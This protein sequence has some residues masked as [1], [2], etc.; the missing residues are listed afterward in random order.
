MDIKERY[1]E[2]AQTLPGYEPR[3]AQEAMVKTIYDVIEAKKSLVIEAGTGS[4]K[5]FGYLIP[6]LL[7]TEKRPIVVSTGT[8][9]LQEQLIHK[10]LPF[11]AQ[12]MGLTELNVQ[13]VKGRRNY[14]CIQK[15]LEFERGLA[16]TAKER[17]YVSAIKAGLES[18][19]DGD[20][21]TFDFEILPEIWEEI[22]SDS[23]DCLGSRCQF[24][25]ENPYK[26]ARENLEK[27]DILVTNHALYLQD[28]VAGQ[29]VLPAHEVVVFDEA[30]QIKNYA[31]RGFTAR[32]GRFA[33]QKLL[34]KIDKRIT[35][36]PEAFYEP[37][38]ENES[39]LMEWLFR[40]EKQTFSL[41]PDEAFHELV[42][43][44]SLLLTELR[45]WLGSFDM[46][47]MTLNTN[48]AEANKLATQR[49]KLIK[50]L[51]GLCG[52]WELFLEASGPSRVHWA[53]IL[54]NRLYYELRST[55]LNI[56]DLLENGLWK[57]KT[58][59]LTSATLSTNNDL[60]YFRKELGLVS[61]VQEAIFESPFDYQHQA[62]LLLP[63]GLPDPNDPLYTA[64]CV[65]NIVDILNYTQG[66]AFVLFTSYHAMHRVS[67]AVVGKISYPCRVMGDMPRQKLVDWFKSTPNS[68]LFATATFWE[69]IDIPGES[70]SCV[71]I[72]KVPFTTP[73]E[74]V[75][76]AM[77]SRYKALGLDWFNDY[78][79][80][81]AVIRLKQ[82]VGR[83]IRSSQDTGLLVIL[84]PRLSSKGYGKKIIRSLPPARILRTLSESRLWQTTLI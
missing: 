84:D 65:E 47:Q 36:I 18:D 56:A 33:T 35:R 25:R 70:L 82:G 41:V 26:K 64:A 74:P 3:P 32:I 71:I 13:L 80:P 83:L 27:A 38:Y 7:H 28:L 4:G 49:E 50:Q 62:E 19:W 9:A 79:L 53:E 2:I 73:D 58:A 20:K 17:L 31:L 1:L 21:A 14:L 77:V 12:A 67:Q 23:E 51:E 75:N 59:I 78:V 42:L 66:R 24:Y 52:R 15:L 72:D 61:A 43:G 8:I 37:L 69:G 48:E 6:I 60:R 44:Q 76:N 29:S 46:K 11:I 30:H 68:I 34:R 39:R 63:S 55:P 57:E 22:Q 40:Q 54:K 45:E 16:Q 5:S 10:D 81:E